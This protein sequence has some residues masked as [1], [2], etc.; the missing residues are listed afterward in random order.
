VIIGH[1]KKEKD[2]IDI[3]AAVIFHINESKWLQVVTPMILPLFGLQV[4]A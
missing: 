4:Q 3:I 1:W 2:K